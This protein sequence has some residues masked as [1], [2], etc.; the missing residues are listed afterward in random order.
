[1][2]NIIPHFR[3]WRGIN[4]STLS[5][6]VSS[7]PSARKAA[8][9]SKT[10]AL[11]DI[12]RRDAPFAPFHQPGGI[13]GKRHQHDGLR[14]NDHKKE[15][16][17]SHNALS[18]QKPPRSA[19]TFRSLTAM[20]APPGRFT[21]PQSILCGHKARPPANMEMPGMGAAIMTNEVTKQTSAT[22]IVTRMKVTTLP[23]ISR[24][25]FICLTLHRS[26]YLPV[27]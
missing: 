20:S 12:E 23:T 15:I 18:C 10:P 26:K 13:G 8:F 27:I 7:T 21:C 16:N 25:V 1:M 22:S 4:A 17:L 11:S 3:T 5:S 9:E 24:I 19:M 2:P 14:Q 6:A